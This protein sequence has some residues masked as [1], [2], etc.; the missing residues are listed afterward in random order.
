MGLFTMVGSGDI[1]SIVREQRE[2]GAVVDPPI[3]ADLRI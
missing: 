2:N 3:V 1:G